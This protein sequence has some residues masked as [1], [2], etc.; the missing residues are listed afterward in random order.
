[1][2]LHKFQT[3]IYYKLDMSQQKLP[4]KWERSFP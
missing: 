1:M 4:R 2:Q 3:P